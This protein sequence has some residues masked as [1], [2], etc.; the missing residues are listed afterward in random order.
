V[1][2]TVLTKLIGASLVTQVEGR[3]H[4]HTWMRNVQFVHTSTE[5]FM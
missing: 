4:T 3:T 1:G 5:V 2:P